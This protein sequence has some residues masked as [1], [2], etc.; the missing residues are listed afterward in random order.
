[1]AGKARTLALFAL[2][3]LVAVFCLILVTVSINPGMKLQ[4]ADPVETVTSP[5]RATHRAGVPPFAC[6]LLSHDFGSYFIGGDDGSRTR[7]RNHLSAA[8]TCLT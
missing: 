2:S 1:M 5:W 4:S 3:R 7:V 8:L 6:L